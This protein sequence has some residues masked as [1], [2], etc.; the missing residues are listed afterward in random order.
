MKA[1]L[2]AAGEGQRMR[3]LT[4]SEPK[5]LLKINGKPLI[6][7]IIDSLTPEITEIII[8]IRYLGDKIKDHLGNE[9]KDRRIFY[10][11]GSDKGNAYSFLAAKPFINNERFMFIYA[12]EFPNPKDVSNCL[13]HDLSVTVFESKNP[14]AHGL[15]YLNQDG[16]IKQIIEKPENPESNLA[17]D[18]IMVLNEKI[19][20]YRAIS[21]PN[22]EFY[23]TSLLDQFVK[24]HK[25][26]P[27]KTSG[28]IGD[29]T[30][31][32]DLDRVG[33][34]LLSPNNPHR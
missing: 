27:V 18:G 14:K 4:F 9:Y 7:Y 24:E 8:V 20:N 19:F 16:S 2:L 30:T 21:H 34:L 25:V 12:D 31:P 22:G 28:F 5:P 17:V 1:I 3:P 11:E 10:I 6:D 26:W 29:I 33:K 23:F 13:K 15:A 32:L